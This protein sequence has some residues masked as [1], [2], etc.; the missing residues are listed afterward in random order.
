MMKSVAAI[1]GSA[2]SHPD[3][4]GLEWE[5]VEV[6]TAFGPFELCRVFEGDRA[7]Y[8]VL[9]HGCPHRWLP[10]QIPYR[11]QAL[12]LR[13][14]GVGSL[15]VTSSVGVLDPDLP[16]FQPLLVADLVTADNRL[17]DGSACSV[18]QQYAEEQ[19][20]LVLEHGLFDTELG[21][22]LLR[23]SGASAMPP[24]VFGY[25]PGPRTK[26]T[27]ENKMWRGFGAQVNS[28]TLAP[29]VILANELGIATAAVVVGHK[30]SLGDGPSASEGE[31]RA[32]LDSSRRATR[33]LVQAFLTR[34]S[35]VAFKNFIYR[36]DA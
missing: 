28:M 1:V 17:P 29:E 4:L 35:A 24:A 36:F 21:E 9:R 20:H 3:D 22:Q 6:D 16:L 26:T 31:I 2:F 7:A 8:L 15:L 18:W 27:A 33:T 11:A 19:G 14:L 25:V 13:N 5:A 32:S 30:Y 23:L 10:H 12:A 34:G